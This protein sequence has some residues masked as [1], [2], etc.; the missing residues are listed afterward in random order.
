MDSIYEF[1]AKEVTGN[2]V[3]LSDF[4]GKVVLIVNT[5]SHCG[6]APQFKGLEAL[7]QKYKDKG[8]V[9]LGFPCDQFANQEKENAAEIQSYCEINFGVT[10]PLFDKIK[11]NGPETHPLFNYLKQQKSG[12]FGSKIKW[13]FT[14]FLIDKNGK[15]QK[16][17]APT[18]HPDKIE[19]FIEKLL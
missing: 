19:A 4:K 14:K 5:A 9:V 13:N 3:A 16:R 11:V 10:F 12:I 17:F 15:P 1:K 18:K 8:L 2:E 7:H 6:L